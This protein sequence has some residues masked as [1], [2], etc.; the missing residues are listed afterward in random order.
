MQILQSPLQRETAIVEFT[1]GTGS[2]F[3]SSPTGAAE[4]EH[5][6]LAALEGQQRIPIGALDS[7]YR[8]N[9][10]KPYTLMIRATAWPES[11]AAAE[12][13]RER[14]AVGESASGRKRTVEEVLAKFVQQQALALDIEQEEFRA[15]GPGSDEDWLPTDEVDT[16]EREDAWGPGFP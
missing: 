9:P 8:A 6:D 15:A 3:D 14:V 2:Q 16:R 1:I 11:T 13:A 7:V 10:N 5:D 12:E 4:P